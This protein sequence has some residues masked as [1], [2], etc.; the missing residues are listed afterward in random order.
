MCKVAILLGT[1]NGEKYI[2]ELL[3]SIFDQTFQEFC[4]YIHDDGST[5]ST[6][7]VINRYRLNKPNNIKIINAPRTGSAR[8]NFFFLMKKV[9]AQYILF[10]DQDDIW[11]PNKIELL[12]RNIQMLEAKN[13][14]YPC[15]VWTDMKVVDSNLN[16][17]SNSFSSYT[18]LKPT[19]ISVDR[20]LVYGKAAGCSIMINN[21]LLKIVRKAKEIDK[22]IMHDRWI[23]LIAVMIGKV[24]YINIPTVLY[25]QHGNNSVG[26]V[27]KT[28]K[29]IYNSIKRLFKLKQLK[30]TQLSLNRNI[31]QCAALRDINEVY[32][33]FKELING[34]NYY[35]SYTRLEK[36]NYVRKSKL[37]LHRKTRIWTYL[38]A[39]F[40]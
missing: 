10:C 27:K 28:N 31:N 40:D 33:H 36:M 7:E 12:Y 34:A 3:D 18:R 38:A 14:E 4:I 23:M 26:A 24:R 13:K 17:I 22:I 21:N 16:V 9:E 30:I 8:N 15:L 35:K 6:M 39:F 37:Y 2:G 25:R 1:Y 19:E 29:D 20:V 5:D 11:L 32:E